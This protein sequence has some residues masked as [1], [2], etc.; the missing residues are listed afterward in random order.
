MGTVAQNKLQKMQSLM[1]SA[2]RLFTSQG[3]ARTSISDIVQ[4][5][6]MAKG[7]FY[8]YFRDKYELQERLVEHET[9]KLFRHALEHSE[10]ERRTAPAEKIIAILDDILS[11]LQKEPHLLRFINKNLSW[12]IFRR[13]IQASETDYLAVFEDILGTGEADRKR[14]GIAIYTII[15]LVGASCH[16]VI[17]DEDPVG[18]DEYKPY[19]YRAVRAIVEDFLQK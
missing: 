3:I 4:Q 16:S 7:T 13:A 9:E 18:L 1:D 14:L 15:E 6:G 12:G 5:A 2:F 17:L 8:L 19:L 11:Q 10:Y